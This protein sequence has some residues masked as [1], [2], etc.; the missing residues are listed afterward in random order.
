VGTLCAQFVMVV[1]WRFGGGK[2]AWL[3]VPGLSGLRVDEGGLIV[4]IFLAL[5]MRMVGL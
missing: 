1:D 2:V 5:R 4:G 3:W